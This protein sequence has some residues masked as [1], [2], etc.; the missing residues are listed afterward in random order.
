VLRLNVWPSC[1]FK[2]VEMISSSRGG[3]KFPM[4]GDRMV[5]EE[6]K[7]TDYVIGSVDVHMIKKMM[8]I[9]GMVVVVSKGIIGMVVVV[10]KGIIGMVVV[11]SKGIIGMVVVVSK[12]IIDIEWM[13]GGNAV[14]EAYF[15]V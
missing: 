13:L 1:I 3:L 9:N 7:E 15:L 14:C 8:I 4:I 10:S 11:V 2:L 5:I 12:G 6:T